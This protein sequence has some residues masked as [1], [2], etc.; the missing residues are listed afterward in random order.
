MKTRER[1]GESNLAVSLVPRLRHHRA[2]SS[3]HR[4]CDS[5]GLGGSVCS[6]WQRGARGSE[7]K[8]KQERGSAS[9]YSGFQQSA[10][11][12]GKKTGERAGESNLSV[13]LI[14]R[15][16]HHRAPWSAH[17][18]CDS[19]GLERS[20]CS[21]WQRGA[22]G[23]ETKLKQ[24]RGSASGYLGYQQSARVKGMKKGERAEKSSPA[25]SLIPRPRHHRTS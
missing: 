7:T 25:V 16:R 14:P 1:A 8:L 19:G 4:R 23:S 11:I 15:P 3:A 20:E 5:G 24:E 21:R 2:P 22:R 18:R 10:R 13:S 9:G 12:K 17:R 6:R